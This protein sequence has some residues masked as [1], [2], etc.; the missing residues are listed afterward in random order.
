VALATLADGIARAR[1][2]GG[3]AALLVVIV[4]AFFSLSSGKRG[5]Y[6]LPAVP[7]LAMAAAPW[8]PELLRAR[9][10]RRLAFVLATLLTAL[11]AAAAV[12]FA[13][14]SRAAARIV[15]QD[16]RQ[17][18]LPLAIVAIAGAAAIWL[19]RERDGWLAYA[20]TLGIL[21]ATTGFVVYPRIDADRSGRAFMARVEEASAGSPNSPGRGQGAV[22]A[23]AA[24]FDHEF[25]AR[26]LAG[27]RCGGGGCVGWLAARPG[28]HCS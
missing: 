9:G 6:V 19:L 24:S 28:R 12:Y 26:A 22:P 2:A 11:T 7:A 16:L 14:D 25:R 23:A 27:G 17:L 4:L 18:I 10:P 3:R 21:L 20:A 8:L 13:V 5:V 1:H 15:D